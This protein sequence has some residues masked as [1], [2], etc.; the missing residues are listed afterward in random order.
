MAANLIGEVGVYGFTAKETALGMIIE[1]LKEV[2]R[3][4][5]KW[6]RD[7]VGERVGRVDYDESIELEVNGKM[8]AVGGFDGALG[9]DLVLA[10]TVPLTHINAVG[11]GMTLIDEVDKERKNEDWQT[12]KIDSEVLPFFVAA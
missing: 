4:S 5:K 3:N 10:N 2:A 12:L 1:S 8:M 9:E 11:P 7:N 6:I